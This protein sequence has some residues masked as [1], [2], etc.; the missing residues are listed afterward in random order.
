MTSTTSPLRLLSSIQHGD[1]S[2]YLSPSSGSDNSFATPPMSPTPSTLRASSDSASAA[3]PPSVAS[4]AG[5]VTTPKGERVIPAT[6]RNDGS[7]RKE[8]RIRPGFVPTED[9]ARYNVAERVQLR[10]QR[11]AREK[12]L[13]EH[14]PVT[15]EAGDVEKDVDDAS[16]VL[17]GLVID[18]D[19][20]AKPGSDEWDSIKQDR[21]TA[22]ASATAKPSERT[23]IAPTRQPKNAPSD[24]FGE[25][26]R[27][28][29]VDSTASQESKDNSRKIATDSYSATTP[30]AVP[31]SKTAKYVEMGQATATLSALPVKDESAATV[32]TACATE[33]TASTGWDAPTSPTVTTASGWDMPNSPA[34]DAWCG[35]ASQSDWNPVELTT[36]MPTGSAATKTASTQRSGRPD[37]VEGH[38]RGRS[39]WK[40]DDGG[41]SHD[42]FR[43]HGHR[44]DTRD[45]RSRFPDRRRNG[46][47]G[48]Y[49][50]PVPSRHLASTDSNGTADNGPR[51]VNPDRRGQSPEERKRAFE[52]FL[53]RPLATKHN[54]PS[55][56]QFVGARGGGKSTRVGAWTSS[57]ENNKDATEGEKIKGVSGQAS[58]PG[59]VLESRYAH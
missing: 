12:A 20:V 55:F 16:K 51:R 57:S 44:D 14:G 18:P 23:R 22:V 31:V 42:S 41:D 54:Y 26:S 5:I 47:D 21:L 46:R 13:G 43:G 3:S 29:S 9:V 34:V 25:W 6:A 11:L 1:S 53:N 37:K 10:R 32:P 27:S 38:E 45:S 30:R 39:G 56:N 4:V 17:E 8:I 50:S 58:T 19:T 28:N 2:S 33:F 52:E 36:S 49:S 24:R 59:K 40:N 15:A 48:D 35:V 7:V